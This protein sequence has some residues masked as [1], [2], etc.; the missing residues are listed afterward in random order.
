MLYIVC[1]MAF[2]WR[3]GTSGLESSL[4]LSSRAELVIRIIISVILA[5][6]V[7]YFILVMNTLRR[8][9]DSMD[10]QFKKELDRLAR[11]RTQG[12]P[13]HGKKTAYHGNASASGSYPLAQN[14]ES[15]WFK[16]A[17]IMDF[18]FQTRV[19]EP[20]PDYLIERG[21]TYENWEKF[22]SVRSAFTFIVN[23]VSQL[24]DQS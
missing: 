18:R 2:V 24:L 3:S 14:N 16:R 23:A 9:G 11:E 7:L 17:K 1:I 15:R 6:G 12:R 22:I 4:N 5:I 8:Y 10:K 19:S 21:F 13:S 20:M